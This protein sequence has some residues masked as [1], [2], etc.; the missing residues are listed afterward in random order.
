MSGIVG[1]SRTGER[2]RVES[3]PAKI[4]HGG[5]LERLDPFAFGLPG[6]PRRAG[7]GS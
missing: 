4:E 3:M 6:A 5:R 1:M 2:S 7:K